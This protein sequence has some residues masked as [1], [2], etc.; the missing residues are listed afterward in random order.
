MKNRLLARRYARAFLDN[1]TEKDPESLR[2]DIAT[3]RRVIRENPDLIKILQSII[4]P[5][6]LKRELLEAII[7]TQDTPSIIL[8][9][10]KQWRGLF[11][12]LI[13]KHRMPITTE[14]IDEIERL[15][16]QQ[17]N[18]A[19]I[20]IVYARDLSDTITKEIINYAGRKT[21]KELIVETEIGPAIIGGFIASVHSII[22]D[23]SVRRNLNIFKKVRQ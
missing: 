21:G 15:L 4:T 1:T 2:K 22:F 9:L 19:R 17:Q 8:N 7:S 20:R 12:L 16:L 5:R 10:P 14:I 11:N 3:M 18:K 13:R 23:G 6:K